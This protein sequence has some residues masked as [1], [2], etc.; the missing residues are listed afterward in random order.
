MHDPLSCF[1]FDPFRVFFVPLPLVCN[2]SLFITT[3]RDCYEAYVIYCFLH[4]LI[5]TLGDG[6]PAANR[7]T[8]SVFDL[9]K[10]V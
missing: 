7:C 9:A 5:G 1:R 6:V 10:L 8:T 3:V 2:R 4:F